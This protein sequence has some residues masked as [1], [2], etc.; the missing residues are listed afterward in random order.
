M[1]LT[2]CEVEVANMHWRHANHSSN[3]HNANIIMP[4]SNINT[5]LLPVN[6]VKLYLTKFI[7][8]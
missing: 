2:K 3:K 6:W 4:H 7:S 8:G 5:L 1:P